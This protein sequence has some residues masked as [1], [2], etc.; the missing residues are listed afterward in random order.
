MEMSYILG[1]RLAIAFQQSAGLLGTEMNV[2][3]QSRFSGLRCECERLTQAGKKIIPTRRNQCEL[4]ARHRTCVSPV[5][6]IGSQV[7]TE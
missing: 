6:L 7:A 3:L 4:I 2:T 1:S 5:Q